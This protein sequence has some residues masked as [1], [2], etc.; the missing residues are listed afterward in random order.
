MKISK[1]AILALGFLTMGVATAERVHVDLETGAT[2]MQ[3]ALQKEVFGILVSDSDEAQEGYRK[4]GIFY[5]N[6]NMAQYQDIFTTICT[7]DGQVPCPEVYFTKRT[8]QGIASMYPNGVL[9]MNEADMGRINLNEATFILAH[10]FAHYK[11]SHSKQRSKVIAQSVVDNAIMIREPEQAVG[12]SMFLPGVKE[13]HYDYENQADAY[14]FAYVTKY[15][16]KIDCTSMFLKI[17][18]GEVINN[19]KHDSVAK[20]CA[21]YK[22]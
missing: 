7:R 4:E 1:L 14:G 16:I 18:N 21:N 20:R 13:A 10:E 5:R 22:G 11:M 2:A 15:G 19:D 8:E 6:A 17:A 12:T 3:I 9:V